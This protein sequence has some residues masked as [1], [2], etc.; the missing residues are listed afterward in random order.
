MSDKLLV[1]TATAFELQP[2]LLEFGA[3]E[4]QARGLGV[5]G[6]LLHFSAFDCLV[7][8]VGQLQCAFHLTALLCTTRYRQVI[9]AGLA[10]SFK[11][12]YSKGSVVVVG[13]EVLGDF[14]AESDSGY[15]DIGD[16][17]LLPPE[18]AP[19][20]RGVLRNP[21]VAGAEHNSL[22]VVRS[23]TVNR[24]LGTPQT[25][26]WISGRYAPDVV[27][28]EGAA[29]FYTCL[30]LGVPFME[31]RAISD[32]VGP[33]DKTAWDIPGAVKALNKT[34]TSLLVG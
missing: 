34:L 4:S 25:I 11:S 14:G 15:L 1:V 7:T 24:T 22:P 10:G 8:G 13:E 12:A 29:L 30:G 6:S 33:R 31:L 32:M 19:F 28:M 3:T 27:N 9:Q 5:A 23:V 21:N 18:Q 16:M 17:G 26:A 20:T 2:T